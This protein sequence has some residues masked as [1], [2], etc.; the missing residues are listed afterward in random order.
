VRSLANDIEEALMSEIRNLNTTLASKNNE[1]EFILTADK[2]F[3]EDNETIQNGL[4]AHIKRLQDK[5]FLVQRE[6]EIELF[7]TVD[8]LRTQY[9]ENIS[10]LN[11]EFDNVRNTHQQEVDKLNATIDALKR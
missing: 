7:Q 11:Q 1:I 3:M 6:S 10:A 9:E 4:K 8:R 2:K 5:I